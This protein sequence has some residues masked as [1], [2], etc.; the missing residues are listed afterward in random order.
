MIYANAK[1]HMVPALLW[2]RESFNM[3]LAPE[4]CKHFLLDAGF[5]AD[6]EMDAEANAILYIAIIS[7]SSIDN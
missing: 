2:H 3:C 1:I 5:L 4:K 6:F 7:S